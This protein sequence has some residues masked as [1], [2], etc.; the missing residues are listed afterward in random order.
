VFGSNWT[1]QSLK[2]LEFTSTKNVFV[3]YEACIWRL[4][5]SRCQ[6]PEEGRFIDG[7][8]EEVTL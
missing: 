6:E 1:G 2:T 4:C 7:L 3:L 5:R 8:S